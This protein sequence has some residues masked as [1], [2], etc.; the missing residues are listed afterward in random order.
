MDD[1]ELAQFIRIVLKACRTNPWLR[2]RSADEFMMALL[3]FKFN[4]RISIWG[5]G[6]LPGWVIGVFGAAIGAGFLIF[7]VWRLV[8][9]LRH[10]E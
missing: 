9:L 2:Y 8:W 10:S 6:R 5:T 4:R 3:S 7:L 1:L